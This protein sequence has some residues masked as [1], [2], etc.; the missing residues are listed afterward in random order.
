MKRRRPC[1]LRYIA[2]CEVVAAAATTTTTTTSTQLISPGMESDADAAATIPDVCQL[3]S[4][5]IRGTQNISSIFV[6]FSFIGRTRH[7]E[8][9]IGP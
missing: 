7:D 6:Q 9:I 5:S 3:L 8:R 1:I 4:L 2:V